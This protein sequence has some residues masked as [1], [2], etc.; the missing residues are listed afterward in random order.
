MP[1]LKAPPPPAG[2]APVILPLTDLVA[3]MPAPGAVIP[4]D[5]S[6]LSARAAAL[7]ARAAGLRAQGFSSPALPATPATDPTP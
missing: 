7:R 2:P 5:P 3:A 1:E 4:T 6:N